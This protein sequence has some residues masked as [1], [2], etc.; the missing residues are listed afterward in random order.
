MFASSPQ[1]RISAYDFRAVSSREC[2]ECAEKGLVRSRHIKLV[3]NR[4]TSGLKPPGQ[5][6][7]IMK[8]RTRNKRVPANLRASSLTT[9]K[10]TYRPFKKEEEVANKQNMIFETLWYMMV[11]TFSKDMKQGFTQIRNDLKITRRFCRG[12]IGL[13]FKLRPID[14][15]SRDR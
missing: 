6:R 10:E 3:C 5:V 12:N 7:T 9:A 2:D 14:D 15:G 1:R 13:N 11:K 8:A 4:M